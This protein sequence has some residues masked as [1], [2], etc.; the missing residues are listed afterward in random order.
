MIQK[1]THFFWNAFL[2]LKTNEKNLLMQN[3]A[4]AFALWLKMSYY[5]FFQKKMIYSVRFD[6]TESNFLQKKQENK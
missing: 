5:Y 1:K 6:R 3:R 4:F 2:K